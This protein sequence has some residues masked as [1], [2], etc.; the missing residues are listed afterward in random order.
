LETNEND[1]INR[2]LDQFDE[3]RQELKKTISEL[4]ELKENVLEMFPKK[5]DLRNK[6]ILEERLKTLTEFHNVI[7]KYRQ[8]LNRTLKDEIEIRRKTIDN[9][10]IPTNI[11]LDFFKQ[12]EKYS[13]K[14]T[15]EVE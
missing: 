9:N 15:E 2:L 11:G 3:N 7:F 1:K 12:I 6:F 10:S 13:D 4:T 14:L 8:E 5:L